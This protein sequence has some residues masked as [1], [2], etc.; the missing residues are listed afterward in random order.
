MVYQIIIGNNG[1]VPNKNEK[2]DFHYARMYAMFNSTRQGIV[3][4][5]Q[6]AQRCSFLRV[7]CIQRFWFV[8]NQDIKLEH[9]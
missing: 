1:I 6:E 3:F 8:V 4:Q 9:V 7:E 5:L 2:M